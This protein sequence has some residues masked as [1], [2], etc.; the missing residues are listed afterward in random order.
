MDWLPT[1]LLAGAVSSGAGPDGPGQF[2]RPDYLSAADRP[3]L[4]ELV[5]EWCGHA[6][7]PLRELRQRLQ[8]PL[9]CAAPPRH[10]LALAC[11][12]LERMCVATR[13][14]GPEPSELRAALFT[15]AASRPPLPQVRRE[16]AAQIG[17][18]EDCLSSWLFADLPGEA[19]VGALP[20]SVPLSGLVAAANLR[21]GQALLRRAVGVRIE[22]V[23]NCRRLVRLARLR[24]LIVVVPAPAPRSQVVCLELSG[25]LS[26]FRRTTVYGT[27]L[28]ALLSGLPWNG[29]FRLRAQLRLRGELL[30][31]E[32][33]SGDP[34]E[35]GC[36]P[37]RH[38]SQLEAR[39]ERDF[40]AVA[41]DWDILREPQPV[42]V[43][44]TL[45]FPDFALQHRRRS[46][47]RWLLEIVGFW[48]VEY[49]EQ[50]LARLRAA[51]MARLILCIDET[52]N[53]SSGA[54]PAGARIV[55]Y[56]RRIDAAA[57]LAIIEPPVG[58]GG[59]PAVG[60]PDPARGRRQAVQLKFE[61]SGSG[62]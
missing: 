44:G 61:L 42:A 51:R 56:R 40:R 14:D 15:A 54:L 60:A 8:E 58:G 59:A 55:R 24:G 32:L 20:S 4:R 45:L 16:V 53:C 41:S 30:A 36:E 49:L 2:L 28:A 19:P 48:T 17:I 26:L 18:P 9:A 7:R 27:A 35:P 23:G 39:F 37:R 46:E 11:C 10:R 12:V 21:L 34:I 25:P 33:R 5:E 50:K 6:G 52:R 57:V 1:E 29:R 13:R 62:E 3:W 47:D 43:A 31:V 22:I 38:D